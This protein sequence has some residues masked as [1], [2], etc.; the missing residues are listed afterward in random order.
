MEIETP[1]LK[2]SFK[3]VGSQF[4]ILVIKRSS[5]YRGVEL[6]IGDE[7]S[8]FNVDY[9][10]NKEILICKKEAYSIFEKVDKKFLEHGTY[11]IEWGCGRGRP[12]NVSPLVNI[13]NWK[14]LKKD[15][16]N[17]DY[18]GSYIDKFPFRIMTTLAHHN[19]NE[20]H[21]SSRPGLAFY[22]KK[23]IYTDV[24]NCKAF[25]DEGTLAIGQHCRAIIVNSQEEANIIINVLN[26]KLI[27]FLSKAMPASGSAV[28]IAIV[29]LLF[30]KIT[31]DID[32]YNFFEFSSNEIAMIEQG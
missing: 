4:S 10:K 23:V 16:I 29:I 1:K 31:E 6:L 25:Y 19:K 12:D 11:P 9:R 7:E 18:S 14:N 15:E 17:Y 21:W 2:E 8:T 32:L 28:C 27:T 22:E 26:S 24:A 20:Y 30:P 13:Q 5:P 3:G